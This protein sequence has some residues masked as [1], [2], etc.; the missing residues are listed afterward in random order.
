MKTNKPV[1]INSPASQ[2]E[3][4]K[5]KERASIENACKE[6][7]QFTKDPRYKGY[8]L[9]LQ[10]R[11][12]GRLFQRDGLRNTAKSNDEYFKMALICDTEIGL[13]KEILEI[14][15]KFVLRLREIQASELRKK[16]EE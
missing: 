6:L 16:E 8:K 13:L 12:E 11:L 4:E 10:T 9:L 7:S 14:P 15:E 5:R 1:V 3:A 2:R